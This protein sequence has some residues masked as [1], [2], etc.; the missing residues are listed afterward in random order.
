MDTFFIISVLSKER[1]TIGYYGPFLS[2]ENAFETIKNGNIEYLARMQ[3]NLWGIPFIILVEEA[4]PS[5][6]KWDP[7]KTILEIE[8]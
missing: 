2:Y 5:L 6:L 7:L 3:F 1:K 8:C 4:I